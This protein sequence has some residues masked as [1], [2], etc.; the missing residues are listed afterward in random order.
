MNSHS[1]YQGATAPERVFAVMKT[2][3]SNR[4]PFL[5]V[6]GFIL[7]SIVPYPLCA[8]PET[9]FQKG[10]EVYA[11]EEY[12]KAIDLYEQCL[13]QAATSALHFNLGNA[14]YN[15]GDIGRAVLNY[16]RSLALS[17][18]NQEAKANLA[19]LRRE[20][21]LAEREYGPATRVG[22]KA[23]I[24][25]WCWT[26]TAGFWLAIFMFTL[27]P[28]YGVSNLATR[29]VT[30]L[31]VTAVLASGI[32]LY[33]YHTKGAEAIILEPDAAIRVAPSEQSNEYGYLRAGETVSVA[34]IHQNYVFLETAGGKSGWVLTTNLSRIWTW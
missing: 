12:G 2:P 6:A 20:L 17:P 15:T 16:E 31:S 32:A 28:L 34:K 30:I 1:L 4:S 9:L 26:A 22:L 25:F 24:N 29:V 23:P 11:L 8:D 7:L 18:G 5:I 3:I 27:P 14:Y 10:N 21:E 13:Q 19:F 33:G